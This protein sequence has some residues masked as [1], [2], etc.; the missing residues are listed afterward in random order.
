MKSLEYK[1]NRIKE[2]YDNKFEFLYYDEEYIKYKCKVCGYENTVKFK[3]LYKRLYNPT[4]CYRCS[5]SIGNKISCNKRKVNQEK[6]IEMINKV[7]EG[8]YKYEPFTIDCIAKTYVNC[9]CLKCGYK[10]KNTFRHLTTRKQGCPKCTTKQSKPETEII[11]FIKTFYNGTIEQ[12]NRNIV[13]SRYKGRYME[14]DI[15]LPEINKAIEFNGSYYHTNKKAKEQGWNSIK[16]KHDYKSNECF[17][18]GITLLHIDEDDWDNNKENI[19]TLIK[20]LIS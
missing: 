1:F 7:S 16:E 10:W 17:K 6:A 9:E 3:S 13:P 15:Y 14:L 12:S 20:A 8:K 5:R 18:K 19:K 11:E 4:E 2:K